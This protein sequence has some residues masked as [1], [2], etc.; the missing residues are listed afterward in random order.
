MLS[1]DVDASDALRVAFE[2]QRHAVVV[3]ERVRAAVF[4]SGQE[5]SRFVKAHASGRPGPN[6]PTGQ[7]RS[8]I[9]VAP[10]MHVTAVDVTAE[11]GT[12]DPQARRLENGFYDMTDELG[13]HFFQPAYPHWGPGLDDE[14]APF[15]ARLRA[16]MSW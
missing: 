7:Y 14:R 2:L 6:A 3:H 1:I 8:H 5:L 11:L 12:N 13:R 16:A 9:P 15:E 10:A 4:L